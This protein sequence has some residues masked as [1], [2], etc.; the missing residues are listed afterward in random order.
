M[1]RYLLFGLL[2]VAGVLAA[3]MILMA[4]DDGG[5]RGEPEVTAGFPAPRPEP[6]LT[7]ANLRSEKVGRYRYRVWPRSADVPNEGTY[8]FSVPHCGL[9]WMTD[10]DGSFWRIVDRASYGKNGPS[11]FINGDSGTLTFEG[12]DDV[13]YRASTGRAVELRRLPGPTII[14]LCG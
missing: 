2:L 9:E 13:T 4:Q 11:F 14:R 7:T 8:R 10:F 6:S 1:K 5:G 3:A 12:D